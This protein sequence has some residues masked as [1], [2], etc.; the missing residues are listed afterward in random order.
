MVLALL[1]GGGIGW[2]AL[3]SREHQVRMSAALT[4]YLNAK[5]TREVAEIA[6][7]EYIE[8]IYKQDLETIECE[9]A[10]AES[11]QARAADRVEWATHMYG[12]GFGPLGPKIEQDHVQTRGSVLDKLKKDKTIEKLN[13]EVEKA[14]ADE[15]AKQADYEREKAAEPWLLW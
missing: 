3:R 15:L 12:M 4:A 14:R 13:S 5:L 9:I 11:D 10:R 6:V 8:G 2:I 7:I 1:V